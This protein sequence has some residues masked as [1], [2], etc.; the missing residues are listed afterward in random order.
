MSNSWPSP[1]NQGRETGLREKQPRGLA[2]PGEDPASWESSCAPELVT[3]FPL[4][5]AADGPVQGAVHVDFPAGLSG[6]DRRESGF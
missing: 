5:D 4:V 6:K 1:G 3:L 2:K